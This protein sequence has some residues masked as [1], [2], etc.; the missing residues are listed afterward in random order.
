MVRA[1][2]LPTSDK[3]AEQIPDAR[4]D[5]SRWSS[6]FRMEVSVMA[7]FEHIQTFIHPQAIIIDAPTREDSFFITAVRSKATEMGKA[8]IEVPLD[9]TEN[10]MWMTRLDSGSLAGL[11]RQLLGSVRVLISCSLANY[12]CGH[13]DTSTIRIFRINCPPVEIYR[14]G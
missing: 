8:L 11:S 13:R 5:Y 6:N 10:L 4:P 12:V 2:S 14:R 7:S 9:A 3:K 1:Y